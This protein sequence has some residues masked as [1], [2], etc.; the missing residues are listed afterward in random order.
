MG[1]PLDQTADQR[2]GTN[3]AAKRPVEPEKR[4]RKVRKMLLHE[5]QN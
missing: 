2:M 1:A 5:I 4:V 3:L